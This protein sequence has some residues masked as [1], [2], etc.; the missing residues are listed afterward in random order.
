MPMY[1]A[2]I[3]F[4]VKTLLILRFQT[5]DRDQMKDMKI[6]HSMVHLNFI[7]LGAVHKRRHQSRGRGVY[8]KMILLKLI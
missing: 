7:V 6:L 2:K 3:S 5:S 8:Q 1:V 4:Y